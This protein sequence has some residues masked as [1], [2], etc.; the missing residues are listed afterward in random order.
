MGNEAA[1]TQQKL[2]NRRR[3]LPNRNNEDPPPSSYSRPTYNQ[4]HNTI[5]HSLEVP[6]PSAAASR[7]HSIDLESV[8]EDRRSIKSDRFR[9][10]EEQEQNRALQKL[11]KKNEELRNQLKTI[12]E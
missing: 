10:K 3:S 11:S 1:T 2:N 12:S 8:D 9:R 4:N 6:P 7:Y 5:N